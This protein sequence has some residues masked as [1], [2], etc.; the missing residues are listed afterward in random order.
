[1]IHCEPAFQN[2]TSRPSQQG[3]AGSGSSLLERS[4]EPELGFFPGD[5]GGLVV[6]TSTNLVNWSV[7]LPNVIPAGGVRVIDLP[8][9]SN[10]AKMLYRASPD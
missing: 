7:F 5:G 9:L 6:K 1:L 10:Q 3:D 4:H 8:V 2:Q